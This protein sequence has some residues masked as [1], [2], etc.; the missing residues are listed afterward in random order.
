MTGS[1]NEW[2]GPGSGKWKLRVY[3]GRDG[4]NRPTYLSRNFTGSRRQ[5]E[6]ALSKLVADVERKQ[7]TTN[8]GGSVRDL[9]TRWLV[10]I[11]PT[12][13]PGTLREHRRS[14]ERNVLP[15]SDRC[16][17]T[18]SPPAISMTSTDPC[19]PGG[20]PL[21]RSGVITPSSPLPSSGSQVGLAA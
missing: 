6:S 20:S 16:A 13:S 10:D 1:L 3:T 19:S 17:S 12:R 5:A 21:R 2:G 8:H 9:L 18:G 7:A 15:R 11:E 14:V 4:R